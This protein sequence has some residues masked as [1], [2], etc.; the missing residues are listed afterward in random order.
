VARD[1]DDYVLDNNLALNAIALPAMASTAHVGTP[2]G[3]AFACGK[4]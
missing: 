4:R 1:A 2:S 3:T